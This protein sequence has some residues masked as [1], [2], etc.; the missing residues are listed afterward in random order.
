MAGRRCLL[1]TAVLAAA[2]HATGMAR[3]TLPAQD[4]LKFIRIARQFQRQPWTD[5]I[6][7]SDQHPLYPALVALAEPVVALAAGHGPDAWRISA[8]GVSAL[9]SI[10]L[11]FP[12]FG[13][14][15]ALFDERIAALAVLIY[16]LLPLPAAV[17]HDTLSDSL[18]L[19]GC[20]LALRLGEIALRPEAQG[21]RAP[22]ACGLVAGLG[23]LARPEV[24]IAPAAVLLAAA[25]R[26]RSAFVPAAS[27]AA[28]PRFSA[29]AV[30]FLTIVG[31]Y[32][33][34][35]G[36]V[37]EKLAMH[38]RAERGT[39]R[40]VVRK[41]GQWLPPGLN[42]PHWDFSPKE[43]SDEP[44]QLPA[45]ETVRRLARE[46]GEGL[47]WLFAFFA[48]WGAVRDRFI[49]SL[50]DGRP[51]G[52]GAGR[53]LLVV[54]LALFALVLVRHGMKMGYLSGR[55]T[56]TLIAVSVPWAAAGTFVCAR[57]LS[58]RLGWGRRLGSAVG[59]TV[60]GAL[61]VAAATVQA[62]PAHPSRW[63]HWAAGRWLIANAAPGEAVLDTRGW[64]AFVSGRP[65]YDYWHV[66]QALTDARLSY[67][68]V[69]TDE[70]NAPSRRAET[71]RA[72]LAHA[73]RPVA[74]FPGREGGRAIGVRVYRFSRP[75]S[76][77]GLRP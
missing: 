75:D 42:D 59:A 33:M 60:L 25:A 66:R 34:V 77:E 39:P 1:A 58:V 31:A 16:V 18:A 32:T 10:A 44:E 52:P 48:V 11:L 57:G 53:A 47:T 61:I 37:S 26:R 55:H 3:A 4:G 54:Y 63:G 71:L 62:K 13:L 30:V 17:G 72:I 64:A 65:G 35:K 50:C 67:V 23:F 28:V 36:E 76:W 8:Q 29:L 56:L 46:W 68:V 15:R 20:L 24:L 21:W 41:V 9:A 49:R 45:L 69:G 40:P 73:A 74:E 2:L 19:L 70:L 38:Q 12:L 43:E 51:E 22:L 14:T 7:G 5:V 6:R 27:N